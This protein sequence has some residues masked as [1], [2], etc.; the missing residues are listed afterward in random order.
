MSGGSRR[1]VFLDR[2]GVIN[3]ALVREGKPYAPRSLLELEILPG[4]PE[5]LASL[6]KA[7]FLNIVVTNQPDVGAGKVPHDVVAA[8]HDRLL[9]DLPL[10]AVKACYHVEA[11]ECDCRKPKP[12]M[13]LDAAREF[14]VHLE[15]SA[16]VGDRWRDVAAGQRAGCRCF[17]VDYGYQEKRP[18]QPF[19][20]VH[21]LAAAATLILKSEGSYLSQGSERRR[22]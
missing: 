10:D 1:A 11:D 2:D 7:G 18:E 15:A 22:E 12:G 13:L 3:R 6:R 8:I 14:D 19:I 4:V 17:F 21:S 5:G 20:A 9:K 16:V